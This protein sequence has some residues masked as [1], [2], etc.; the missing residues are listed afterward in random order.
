MNKNFNGDFAIL[1]LGGWSLSGSRFREVF[2]GDFSFYVFDGVY[3]P[4]EDTFLIADNLDVR[5]GERVLDVGTGCGVLAVLSAVNASWVLATDINPVAV[6]CAKVNAR[7]NGVSDKIEFLCCDLFEPIIKE[8]VF[9]LVLFN[10]PYLPVEEEK[11]KN[12]IDYAWH[13]G[14]LGREVIDRF[15]AEAFDYLRHGGR[16]LLV[17]SSLSNAEETLLKLRKRGYKTEI[18]DERPSFFERI[19]LIES[20]KP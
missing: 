7:R 1:I 11:P 10:A 6:K 20:I 5:Y 2:Y 16:I 13:G 4:A 15:L 19:F 3:E 17:Q 18:I 12:W 8:P 14:R 9:D